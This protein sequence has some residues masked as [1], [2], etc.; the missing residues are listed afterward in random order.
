MSKKIVQTAG[1]EA[2]GE[3]APEFAHFNDDVLFGENWNNE[4]LDLKTRS[5][6]TV[7]A[8]M[9][10]GITDSSLK[11]HIQNAKNHGVSQ[12]EMAAAITH[13]AFYAGWPKAW[14]TFNLAKEIYTE[15][16]QK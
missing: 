5:L 16:N 11:Y 2:L 10:Q 13:V 12:K 3:F 15:D 9:A 4:D 7:V 8:L 1:R 6:I 14:A